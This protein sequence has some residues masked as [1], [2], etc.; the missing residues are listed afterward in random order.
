MT[1]LAGPWLAVIGEAGIRVAHGE[2]GKGTVCTVL[3]TAHKEQ[4]I[5][6]AKIIA[7]A[8]DVIAILKRMDAAWD[9]GKAEPTPDFKALVKRTI[10]KATP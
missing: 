8:P 5:A 10:A 2:K 4:D 9:A 7:A 3:R 1:P 6:T